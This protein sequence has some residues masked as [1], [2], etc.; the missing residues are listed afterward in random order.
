M[1]KLITILFLFL[2]V[3]SYGQSELETKIFKYFNEYRIEHGLTPVEFNDKVF[4]STTHHNN[5]LNDNGYPYNS[6]LSNAHREKELVYVNDR[7]KKYGITTLLSS[8]ECIAYVFRAIKESD[9]SV[10]KNTIKLWDG[11]PS[12]K[13]V[14]LLADIDIGAISVLPLVNSNGCDYFLVTLNVVTLMNHLQ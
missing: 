3:I 14:M 4:L 1:K 13:K 6:T 5:Y 12:H 7:I 10:L 8:G 9:D 2:S 11:S